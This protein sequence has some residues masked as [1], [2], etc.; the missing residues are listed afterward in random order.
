[1]KKE[2]ERPQYAN[3]KFVKKL[4]CE[5]GEIPVGTELTMYGDNILINGLMV[6]PRYYSFFEKLIHDELKK[7]NFLKKIGAPT[8]M[9]NV[10]ES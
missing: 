7:A 2:I 1:M 6:D 9:F 4:I 5:M 10:T 3:F 8:S